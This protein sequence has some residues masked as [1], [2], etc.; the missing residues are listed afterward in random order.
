[1]AG[2]CYP[3]QQVSTD[4]AGGDHWQR[5]V[6]RRVRRLGKQFRAPRARAGHKDATFG[7]A[8]RRGGAALSS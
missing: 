1:M 8:P 4:I 3:P 5:R 7:Q 2:A 6:G